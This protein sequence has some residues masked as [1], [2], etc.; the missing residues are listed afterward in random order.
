MASWRSFR[1]PEGR[2]DIA[3][4]N[5]TLKV[6]RMA[7][8]PTSSREN[9][10][11]IIS[12][13]YRNE[14]VLLNDTPDEA[15]ERAMFAVWSQQW[16]RLRSEF[17]FRTVQSSESVR[18]K[19]LTIKVVSNA[20]ESTGARGQEQASV[21]A[22]VEWRHFTDHYLST[23]LLVAVRQRRR[24]AAPVVSASCRNS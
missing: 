17:S 12:S 19:G 13:Y 1:R 22:A 16:P 10:A 23:S 24:R 6:K 8:S 4:Y 15:F 7:K 21:E 5:L 20:R 9:V 11:N 18:D 2:A 3:S 14:P